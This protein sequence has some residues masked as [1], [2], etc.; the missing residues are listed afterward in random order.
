VAGFKKFNPGCHT[1]DCCGP[2]PA[3]SLCVTVY[4]CNNAPLS[5]ATVNVTGPGSFSASCTTNSV[6]QCCVA[7]PASGTY[8]Y[9]VSATNFQNGTGSSSVTC[10]G[11]TNVTITLTPA[12]GYVCQIGGSCCPLP[13]PVNITITDINGAHTAA[14]NGANAG[15]RVI[16]NVTVTTGQ[17]LHP[18]PPNPGIPVCYKDTV[19]G[20]IQHDISMSCLSSTTIQVTVLSKWTSPLYSS[21]NS[22]SPNIV[23]AGGETLFSPS[24]CGPSG[25][26]QTTITFRM[27][28]K[29]VCSFDGT[30]GPGCTAPGT[31]SFNGTASVAS[32]CLSSGVSVSCPG[33]VNTATYPDYIGPTVTVSW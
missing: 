4:G 6:G 30:G 18:Y 2:P 14:S 24:Y 12:S 8:S 10:P 20:Q 25:T 15:Y 27:V 17:A 16:Y 31:T 9:A 21:Q 5:G 3:C 11:T 26:E 23:G 33:G 19:T 1:H 28:D 32:A 7:I 29:S 13:L 22:C